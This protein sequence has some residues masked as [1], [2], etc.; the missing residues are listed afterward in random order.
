MQNKQALTKQQL[1][2]FYTIKIWKKSNKGNEKSMN[3]APAKIWRPLQAIQQ[4][5]MGSAGLLA[6]ICDLPS[7]C[8]HVGRH[9]VFTTYIYST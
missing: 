4:W 1:T 5:R 8:S 9:I 7:K 6:K 2:N 3:W